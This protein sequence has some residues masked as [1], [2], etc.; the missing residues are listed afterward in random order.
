MCCQDAAIASVLQRL[1]SMHANDVSQARLL[2]KAVHCQR[3]FK[4]EPVWPVLNEPD[5][6]LAVA[7]HTDAPSTP[8]H[9]GQRRDL[10]TSGADVSDY[11]CS[12][13]YNPVR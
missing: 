8:E 7:G 3:R 6:W 11:N 9:S 10:P 13:S 12:P 2:V 1:A 5:G 4:R